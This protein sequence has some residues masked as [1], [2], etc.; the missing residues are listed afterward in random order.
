MTTL[1][2]VDWSLGLGHLRHLD[3]FWGLMEEGERMHNR[4]EPS[5]PTMCSPTHCRSRPAPPPSFRTLPARNPKMGDAKGQWTRR[6]RR[7]EPDLD[8]TCPSIKVQVEV[9]DLSILCKFVCDVL[10]CSF[11]VDVCDHHNPPFNSWER[12]FFFSGSHTGWPEGE[13]RTSCCLGLCRGFHAVKL[14]VSRNSALVP[15]WDVDQK[16][17]TKKERAAC[18]LPP[19]L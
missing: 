6:G 12:A 2:C 10:F 4:I 1:F 9:F 15:A 18:E 5:V 16:T 14:L 19:E 11:L 8:I 13:G 17:R 7:G 3:P